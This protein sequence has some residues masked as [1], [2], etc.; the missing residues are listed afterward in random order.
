MYHLVYT[1]YAEQTFAESDLMLLLNQSRSANKPKEITGLL[2]HL[3]GKFIQVLEGDKSEVKKLYEKIAKD[4]RH[5]KVTTVIEGD[6]PERLFN[7]WSMGF[8]Q[9][10]DDEFEALSG[11]Q[12][13]DAFFEK[14]Q[15]LEGKNLIMIFLQLFYKKNNTDFP[16][17]ARY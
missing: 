10:T 14:Q 6:Y 4:T 3:Q 5:K 12:N 2:L 16:E 8:K 13:M 7:D 1:S 11:F 15:G 9:I 17:P